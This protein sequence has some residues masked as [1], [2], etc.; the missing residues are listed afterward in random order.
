MADF[1]EKLGHYIE[2]QVEKK[3]KY[4]RELLLN[5]YRAYGLE[6]KLLPK[7]QLTAAK[8]YLTLISGQAIIRPLKSPEK[9]VLTSIFTPCEMMHAM[10]LYP[11]CAEQYA[12]YTNG[13]GAEHAFVE[14]AEREGISET[15][16]SYH[17]VVMGAAA[18]GVL[19]KP[20]AV[21][22]TSLACDANNLTFR[23]CA[24]LLGAPQYYIDI[25]YETDDAAVGYVAEQLKEVQRFLE[26]LTGK[27]LRK[28]ALAQS[29]DN[30]RRTIHHL[31]KAIPL[32]ADHYVPA[33]LTA[34][35]YEVLMVHNALGLPETLRYAM[36]L[37]KELQT[38]TKKP[39]RKIL[40]MHSNPFYQ[41][42]MKEFFNYQQDPHIALTEMCY[43]PL[44]DIHET[45]PYR[46]MAARCVYNSFN[47][48]VTR[49]A[50]RAVEKARTIGADGVIL[51]C[52]FGCKETCGAS[53]V[54]EEALTDAGFPTIIINGDGVDRLNSPDGQMKTR[55]GAFLE[56]IEK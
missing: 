48:P 4:A 41:P 22:N 12:T 47:G 33:E 17:K 56:M 1:V 35:L 26:E 21:V 29:I 42:S 32:R 3:P 34:E 19:P 15:F 10:D 24:E 5:A 16:C 37:R 46:F 23:K 2:K 40:W 8:R 11:M 9:Q 31:R 25:P 50:D 28:E 53:R 44:L 6:M 43:D 55:V 14:A 7:K 49:R 27:K 20:L 51:F 30:A 13:A 54:I 39:G 52:H 45:D 18:A 36:M 38:S